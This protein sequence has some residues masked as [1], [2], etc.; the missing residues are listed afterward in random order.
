MITYL[1]DT[2]ET[3]YL[4]WEPNQIVKIINGNFK[5]NQNLDINNM[6]T[7]YL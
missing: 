3:G 1:L 6:V 2:K 7:D 5:V 4:L